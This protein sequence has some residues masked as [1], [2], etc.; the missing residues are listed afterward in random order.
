ML[1]CF[2]LL[3]FLSPIA[4]T[5]ESYWDVSSP[6]QTKTFGSLSQHSPSPQPSL[7][8]AAAAAAAA[9]ASHAAIASTPAPVHAGATPSSASSSVIILSGSSSAP[10]SGSGSSSVVPSAASTAASTGE[11]AHRPLPRASLARALAATFH[12]PAFAAAPASAAT[13]SPLEEARIR[14]AAASALVS[15]SSNIA[16]APLPVPAVWTPTIRGH[17]S[18]PITIAPAPVTV[19]N[20]RSSVLHHEAPPLPTEYLP[21]SQEL[22][23]DA[24]LH[25]HDDSQVDAAARHIPPLSAEEH[26]P[27]VQDPVLLE[28]SS[29]GAS[30]AF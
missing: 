22:E 10:P 6:K 8:P 15:R 18:P 12:S 28:P 13:H 16:A 11:G 4:L 26:Q 2:V 14:T 24:Q 21:T 29:E 1:T 19:L 23:L 7:R 5:P 30:L 27:S 25:G 3:S 9:S 20:A 17:P